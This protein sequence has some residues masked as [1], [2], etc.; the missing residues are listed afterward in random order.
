VGAI[1]QFELE[2][3]ERFE[4]YLMDLIRKMALH[5]NFTYSLEILEDAHV[6]EK[7]PDGSWDGMIGLLFNYEVRGT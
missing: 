4:G 6:G 1:Y 2:G 7:Q 5:L 3:E